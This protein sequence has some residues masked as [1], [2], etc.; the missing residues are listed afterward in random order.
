MSR[1][2]SR[3]NKDGKKPVRL[4]IYLLGSIQNLYRIQKID[5]KK[6]GMYGDYGR[7]WRKG[8][9]EIIEN[10]RGE[11]EK[12]GVD[13]RIV[14][15]TRLDEKVARSRMDLLQPLL[16][17]LQEKMKIRELSGYFMPIWL[18]ELRT[19]FRFG[20]NDRVVIISHFAELK[21]SGGSA[22]ELAYIDMAGIPNY[23]F[24]PE[25]VIKRYPSRHVIVAMHFNGRKILR[26]KNIYH[27]AEDV[28]IALKKDLPRILSMNEFPIFGKLFFELWTK[29]LLAARKINTK[30]AGRL[31]KIS[32]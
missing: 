4:H 30:T 1:R 24:A 31:F 2:N 20:P 17:K 22:F 32:H 12:L 6:K 15:P 19:L 13:P 3:K 23:L 21:V 29:K 5:K 18:A 10:V 25:D 27:S 28:I 16:R 7:R 11:F 8:I 14:D 26:R 9:T